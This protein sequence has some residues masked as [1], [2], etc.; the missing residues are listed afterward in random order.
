MQPILRSPSEQRQPARREGMHD[1][2]RARNI[3]N[4]VGAADLGLEQRACLLG[5]QLKV[6]HEEH[7]S[8]AARVG[9]DRDALREEMPA[10]VAE[11]G[12][13][14]AAVDGRR[15]VVRMAF[16]FRA[17]L[18]D[19]V[20]NLA[21]PRVVPVER[22]AGRHAG[23]KA[24][25]RA[26]EAAR[27]W[28][29]VGARE[30]DGRDRRSRRRRRRKAQLESAVVEVGLVARERVGALADNLDRKGARALDGEQVVLSERDAEAV[31]ARTH[32]RARRGHAHAHALA[33]HRRRQAAE[34]AAH[35][36]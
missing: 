5:R 23:D 13:L 20:A 16:L 32:V 18:K 27:G 14:Q 28:D 3:E 26:A 11:E 9:V 30:L 6:G 24:R 33:R 22:K 31:E 21:A 17:D 35:H 4:S 8:R 19:A 15:H 25:R 34:P 2:R 10:L 1:R 36:P 29:G 7:G 12:E